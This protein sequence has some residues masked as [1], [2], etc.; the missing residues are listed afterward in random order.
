[1]EDEA[2]LRYSGV[3]GHDG[4]PCTCTSDCPATWDG[5]RCGCE[6]CLHAWID[7]G[8]DRLIAT[9]WRAWR[10]AT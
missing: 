7:S 6:A 9:T 10:E 3:D 5:D 8:L 1:M 4:Y 2:L